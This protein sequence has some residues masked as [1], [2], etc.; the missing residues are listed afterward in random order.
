MFMT[1]KMFNQQ[2][3]FFFIFQIEIKPSGFNKQTEN[4]NL[5]LLSTSALKIS[6]SHFT[7]SLLKKI[8]FFAS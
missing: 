5:F 4:S 2:L 7:A 3:F 8:F 1:I 6:T